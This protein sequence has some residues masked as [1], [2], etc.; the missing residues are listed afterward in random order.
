MRLLC[1]LFLCSCLLSSC[2]NDKREQIVS[3]FEEGKR[4][5][6]SGSPNAAVK[7]YRKAADLSTDIDDK[8]LQSRIYNHLGNLFLDYGV[9]D[10]AMEV[11]KEALKLSGSLPDKTESSTAYRGIGKNYY[12]SGNIKESLR[13]FLLAQS[14]ENHIANCEEVASIY[15]NLSNAY[16]DLGNYDKALY[17]NAKAIRLTKDSLKIY[18]N[19]A[20]RG[21]LYMLTQ[22]YDSALHYILLASKSEDMR[23]RASSYYKLSDMP[24]SSGITDSMKYVF[25]SRA[26]IL[27]DSIEDVNRS[28]Q[29]VESEHLHQLKSFKDK[30]QDKLFYAVGLIILIV[31]SS[32]VY[33]YKRYKRKADSYERIIE[34]LN[35]NHRELHEEREQNNAEREK[36]FI[37]IINNTGDAC[38]EK[39]VSL[40]YLE[41]LKERLQQEKV[42][43]YEEQ[44][45]LQRKVFET[46]DGYIRQIAVVIDRLSANDTL[47]CCLSLLKLSTK[48]CAACRG[49]SCE[50]IRSQRTRIKKKIPQ[51]LLG[52]GFMKELFGDE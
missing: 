33:F 46:F 47:L 19:S 31:L 48:E 49:V 17:C 28:V 6:S 20:V 11:H 37:S 22:R 30:E 18:R 26:K 25:L 27:S 16:C 32:V 23:V 10:H 38:V 14:L 50:T 24:V 44:N 7:A 21:R 4:M 39:F 13:Y 51:N 3:L 42:L 52:N 45:E 8:E 5:E 36:Q 43:N 12:L 35:L 9:Y 1:F 15:N 2:L 29:I 34:D 40:G 41:K